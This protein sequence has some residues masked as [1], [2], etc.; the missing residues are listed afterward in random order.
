VPVPPPGLLVDV[1]GF[2][3]HLNSCGAG[4][5]VVIFDA[6]LGG[7][8]LSWSLVQPQ[9]GQFT[10]ACSYDRAGFGWSDA[11]PMPRT[12]GR[13]ADELHTLMDRANVPPPYVLVGHSFGALVMRIFA[14]RHRHEVAGL[15]LVE[16]AFPEDWIEPNDYERQRMERGVR[17]C[18]QGAVAARLGI[19]RAVSLLV[20]AGAL[21]P[22]RGLV[23]MVSRGNLTREHEEI[24]APIWRL[25]SSARAALQQMWTRPKFFEALGSQIETICQSAG[26]VLDSGGLSGLPLV[27]VSATHPHPHHVML[28]ERLAAMS[29]QGRRIVAR[30]SGHWVPLEE[31]DIVVAAVREVTNAVAAGRSDA[32]AP[33]TAIP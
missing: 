13:I 1:G 24:L 27:V 25:P 21:A 17:L 28:Q 3:L 33:D 29:P 18:R 19:A 6:A 32:P 8:S 4:S 12:A 15:V 5:P 10:R 9:V 11:G 14:A 30:S 23:A 31:P 16:P 7:S 26:E 22:A 2:R 20:S